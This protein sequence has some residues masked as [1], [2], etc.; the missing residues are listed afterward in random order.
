MAFDD[1]DAEIAYLMDV[2]EGEQGDLREI[3]FRLRQV[4]STLRAEGLPVPEDLKKLE[5]DLDRLLSSE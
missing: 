1:L 2:M 3:E 4:I 5:A